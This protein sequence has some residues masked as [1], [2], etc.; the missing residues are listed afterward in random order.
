M[1]ADLESIH[2]VIFAAYKFVLKISGV[3]LDAIR[4]QTFELPTR[5]LKLE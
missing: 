5:P 4:A 1:L 2:A 3:D